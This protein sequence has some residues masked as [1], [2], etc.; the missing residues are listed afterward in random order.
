M[1][2]ADYANA[3]SM[4]DC[5]WSFLEAIRSE[6]VKNL[7][8]ILENKFHLGCIHVIITLNNYDS[9]YKSRKKLK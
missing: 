9:V 2:H 1:L 3:A 6:D 7:H 4:G 5:F 8:C